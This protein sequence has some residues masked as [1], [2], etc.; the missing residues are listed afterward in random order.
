MSLV[1]HSLEIR[2][3]LIFELRFVMEVQVPS[4]LLLSS[5]GGNRICKCQRD[6]ER[7]LVAEITRTN[8]FGLVAELRLFVFPSPQMEL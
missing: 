2:C 6:E 5:A 3:G 4:V 8:H 7:C 1:L